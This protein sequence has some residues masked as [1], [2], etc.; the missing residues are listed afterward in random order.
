VRSLGIFISVLSVGTWLAGSSLR[1]EPGSAADNTAVNKRDRGENAKTADQQKNDK[2]D[3]E[4]VAAI[5]RS[6]VKDKA[7]S[8]NAH[9]VKIIVVDGKVTLKGP[10][11]SKDEKATVEKKAAEVVGEGKGKIVNEISVAP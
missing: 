11:A 10:V 6:I 5:R 8:T 2:S 4:I 7:L 1:A 3:T 9:N